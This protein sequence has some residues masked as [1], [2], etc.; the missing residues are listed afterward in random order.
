MVAT[1]PV[2]KPAVDQWRAALALEVVADD[3][4]PLDQ[5]V[6]IGLAVPGQLLAVGVDDLHVH[7]ED[8]PA[9][10]E[11]HLHLLCGDIGRCL[12]LSVHTVPSGD[13]SVMPQACSTSTPYT[14]LKAVIMAGG[15]AEP[16]ITVRLSVRELQ[17]VGL[18]VPQ[19]HLPHRRHAGGKGDFFTFDQFEDG[20]AVHGRARKHHLAPVMAAE[21]GRP[22]ALTWNIGTTGS[23]E[24]RAL[25]FSASGMAPAKACSMV[26]RWL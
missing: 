22:Q 21:Y 26:E 13:I 25:M 4:R 16:P 1:S 10:L 9:L 18:H 15:Q 24:S 3:P 12:F 11:P 14:S 2:G 17:L 8:A 20:L 6:A 5:Q 7:A 19:H 23:T